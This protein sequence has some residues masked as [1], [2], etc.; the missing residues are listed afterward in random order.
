MTHST[1]AAICTGSGNSALSCIRLSGPEARSIAAAV[2]RPVGACK[3]FELRTAAGYTAAYGEIVPANNPTDAGQTEAIDEV[4]VLVFA[5]PHSFTG[6]DVVE[7][8]CHGGEF[9]T[10]AVLDAL[11]SAGAV[12]AAAGAFTRRAFMNGKLDLSGAEAIISTINSESAA[13]LKIAGAARHGRISDETGGIKSALI[14]LAAALTVWADFPEDDLPV[15]TSGEVV[16]ALEDAGRRLE[17]LI[18]SYGY[19]ALLQ[20]GIRTVIAGKPNVGKSSVMNLLSGGERS[21]VTDVAG[22]TRDI[23]SE[24]VRVGGFTL[25][26]LDTAG[27]RQSEDKVE[28]IGVDRALNE[29]SA[30]DL[31][32][33]VADCSSP[34]DRDDKRLVS[35]LKDKENVL[36]ILNK[37]DLMSGE[38][39]PLYR[40]GF[41]GSVVMSAADPLHLEKLTGAILSLPF[42]KDIDQSAAVLLNARQLDCVRR[43]HRTVTEALDSARDEITLDAVGVLIDEAAACLMEVSGE[44]VSEA[45]IDRVFNQ[46]CIGK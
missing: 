7:I 18:K 40:S 26:L 3:G 19:T 45:V 21:I 31:I 17:A 10:K 27:I 32:L 38:I 2:F 42:L 8:S 23:V 4:V 35:Q 33:L 29:L 41:R 6:E 14:N 5:A 1:I 43:A 36:L 15:I 46:F 16:S 34:P 12:P 11:L 44:S 39:D 13:Q 25:K 24:T 22:T 9:V 30:A 37:S 28:A 20:N